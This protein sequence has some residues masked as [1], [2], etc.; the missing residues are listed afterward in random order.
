MSITMRHAA[1]ALLCCC[2][3]LLA[4][5]GWHLRG[6]VDLPKELSP[7]FIAGGGTVGRSLD[8][9]L[10]S[11]GVPMT[12]SPATAGMRIDIL[13]QTRR[14]RVVAVDEN[15]KALAYELLYRVRFAVSDGQGR[16]LIAPQE[17]RL[18]RTFDDNPDVSVLGKSLEEGIIYQD[19]ADDI[20]DQVILRLRALLA[21][22][23]ADT[24]RLP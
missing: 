23:R 16:E 22:R 13:S 18:E 20:A 11:S 8:T 24:T 15:G 12:S 2:V 19:L 10:S 14:S 3:A 17:L 4:A 6:S 1:L 21:G 9:R 7:V 5:C